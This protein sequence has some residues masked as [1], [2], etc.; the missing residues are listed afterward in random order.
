M[1]NEFIF[2]YKL[3]HISGYYGSINV[4]ANVRET[5]PDLDLSLLLN[6]YFVTRAS[7]EYN[8]A[9]LFRILF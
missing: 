2:K 3:L 1:M 7:R 4:L 8:K 6:E 5:M 9:S